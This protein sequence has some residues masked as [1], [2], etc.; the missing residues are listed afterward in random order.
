MEEILKILFKYPT[1]NTGDNPSPNILPC[2]EELSEFL[3]NKNI[4]SK[5]QKYEVVA[6]DK[7]VVPRANLISY[8]PESKGPYIIL[9]GHIDTV[10]F[11]QDYKFDINKEGLT[12]R[13]AVDMKGSLAAMI[14]A[15]L[16][17]YNSTKLKFSPLL[18]IT[19]DEEANG[20]A[21]IYKFIED[22]KLPIVLAITGEPTD[23]SVAKKLR[24]LMAYEFNIRGEGGHSSS[25]S[26]D[27]LIE[28]TIPLI[29]A[30]KTFLDEARK[31]TNREFGQT[32]GAFTVLNAG[33]KSNQL[34][35][36]LRINFNLRTVVNKKIYEKL[37]RK[38]VNPLLS[39]DI[40]VKAIVL[41]PRVSSI[42]SE[43]QRAIQ[44][45]YRTIGLKYKESIFSA[46][47]EASILNQK[48]I[49]AIVCGPGD[50][51]RAHVKPEEESIKIREL[52]DY[53]RLIGSIF[54]EY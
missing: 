38:I 45:A 10:P 8:N 1:D 42:K 16:L 2:L 11:G 28:K 24:G 51:L 21:G 30:I 43:T 7:R 48:G 34:P 41:E 19:G 33:V 31:I 26:N 53:S 52:E 37:Y 12:G 3:K 5:L 39:N 25:I 54:S 15:F 18:L 27:R 29:D 22:N 9:Q 40:E 17:I 36:S 32:I 14:N 35:E 44:K 13:G 4:H 20:F 46:F 49:P 6:N 47:S 23:F 50:I